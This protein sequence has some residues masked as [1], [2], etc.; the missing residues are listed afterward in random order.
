MPYK[1]TDRSQLKYHKERYNSLVQ[2]TEL[3]QADRV[4][5][6]LLAVVWSCGVEGV[7]NDPHEKEYSASVST[8]IGDRTVPQTAEQAAK[9]VFKVEAP[10]RKQIGVSKPCCPRCKEVLETE[11]VSYTSFHHTPVAADRWTAPF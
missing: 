8:R 5:S 2:D 11:E 10:G 3:A 7:G 1:A 6:Y 9:L 4:A